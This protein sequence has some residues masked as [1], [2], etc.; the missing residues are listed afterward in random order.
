MGISSL[1]H[2]KNEGLRDL[3]PPQSGQCPGPPCLP[4]RT[5]HQPRTPRSARSSCPRCPRRSRP[6]CG[7]CCPCLRSRPR[8]QRLSLHCVLSIFIKVFIEKYTKTPWKKKKKKKKPPEKKKKKK[9][10][11]K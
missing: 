6:P 2:N 3:R 11:K 8:L 1:T 7:A 4:C 10:K 5:R 9:K